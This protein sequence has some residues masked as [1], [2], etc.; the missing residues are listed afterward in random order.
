MLSARLIL[1]GL[2]WVWGLVLFVLLAILSSR[3]DAT[4]AWGWFLPNIL[5]ILALV[6]TAAYT[7]TPGTRS[8]SISS[9]LKT[10]LLMLSVLTSVAYLAMLTVAVVSPMYSGEPIAM[11]LRSNLWLTPMQTLALTTLGAFFVKQGKS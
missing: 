4:Q 9:R 2:W 10:P 3:I 5:P 11:M 8:S 1:T 6:G 7:V